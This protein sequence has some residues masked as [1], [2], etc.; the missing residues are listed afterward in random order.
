[1]STSS[2]SS[3]LCESVG[4][5]CFEKK[6]AKDGSLCHDFGDMILV[7]ETPLTIL[8]KKHG[9]LNDDLHSY[10]G[11]FEHKIA[12]FDSNG[13]SHGERMD[14]RDCL[15]TN[16]DRDVLLV[17]GERYTISVTKWEK[18]AR[19]MRYED[20]PFYKWQTRKGFMLILNQD[21]VDTLTEKERKRLCL[22]N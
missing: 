19:F 20:G 7:K 3:I 10:K 6:S 2:T 21:E 15:K 11:Y 13:T 1:M 8:L 17:E 4:D 12:V 14:P 9:F 5:F 18:E 22:S 16:R